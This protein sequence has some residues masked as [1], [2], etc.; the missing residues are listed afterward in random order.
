M[1][2]AERIW[3]C[4]GGTEAFCRLE[5]WKT[6]LVALMVLLHEAVEALR[7]VSRH[8]IWIAVQEC[9]ELLDENI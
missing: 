4:S 7:I 1:Q 5:A 9:V 8:F 3:R 6:K 2:C